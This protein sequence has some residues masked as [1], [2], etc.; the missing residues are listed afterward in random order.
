[1]I[2]IVDY[3]NYCG[4]TSVDI[5]I[6]Q[7]HGSNLHANFHKSGSGI[8][9]ANQRKYLAVSVW[10]SRSSNI[11]PIFSLRCS[12]YT[13]ALTPLAVFAKSDPAIVWIFLSKSAFIEKI[14]RGALML[15]TTIWMATP[16]LLQRSSKSS[17][18]NLC[19]HS[20]AQASGPRDVLNSD[21]LPHNSL[22]EWYFEF[23]ACLRHWKHLRQQLIQGCVGVW[24]WKMTYI[25]TAKPNQ[26]CISH[27]AL[28]VLQNPSPR[29]T[30]YW[31]NQLYVS[32]VVPQMSPR[33]SLRWWHSVC[34]IYL[35]TLLTNLGLPEQKKAWY[36]LPSDS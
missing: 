29:D 32:P 31:R 27:T 7:R 20:D 19:A 23:H 16:F 18:P 12:I 21:I 6:R 28:H 25:F 24:V 10:P 35:L 26:N 8:S 5:K 4:S 17:S 36:I 15:F 2:H 30:A 34:V 33:P 13:M 3:D 14:L 22:C 9:I 11:S 1:M